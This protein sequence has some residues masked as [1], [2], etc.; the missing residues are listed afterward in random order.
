[1]KMHINNILNQLQ[2]TKEERKS[3]A[4]HFENSTI[5]H[6]AVVNFIESLRK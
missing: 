6:S 3:I 5:S 2:A 1:M 4:N